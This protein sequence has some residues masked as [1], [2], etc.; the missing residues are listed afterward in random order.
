MSVHL[1]YSNDKIVDEECIKLEH[2]EKLDYCIATYRDDGNTVFMANFRCTRWLFRKHFK[3][4]PVVSA[5]AMAEGVDYHGIPKLVIVDMSFKTS[6][7]TQRLARQAN[8]NRETEIIVDILVCDKPAV[9]MAV[10]D[11]VAIKEENFVKA[12]YERNV[13]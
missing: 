4:N 10:Y 1:D 2:Q 8:H 6:K 5:D 13:K 7:H 12:S 11:S 3:H 9:G